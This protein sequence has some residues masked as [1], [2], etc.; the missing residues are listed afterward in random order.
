MLRKRIVGVITVR[1]GWAVQSFGYGRY[2]PLGRPEILARNLDRWGADEILLQCIDR[3]ASALGPDFALIESVARKGIATPLIYAGGLRNADDGVAVVHAGAD[4]VAVD[5]M[6][7]DAPDEVAQLE[8]RLGAQAVI[9]ALPLSIEAE[10]LMHKNYRTGALSPLG[11]PVAEIL[12]LRTVSEALVIDWKNDGGRAYDTRLLDAFPA[13]DMP[14]IAFGG[15]ASA[16]QLRGVLSR[17]TVAAAG[18]GNSLNYREH[19]VRLLKQALGDL[20]I[21]APSHQRWTDHG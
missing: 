9:A 1:G 20:P 10:G 13:V 6:L 18:V 14:V 8:A 16:D 15:L 4:R 19:T 11:G 21:R 5:A 2:L 3:S 17:P 7:W 12:R